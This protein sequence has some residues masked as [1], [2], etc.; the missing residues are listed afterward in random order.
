MLQIIPQSQFKSVPWKNGGGTTREAIRVP[1]QGAA[2]VWRVSVA[3]IDA[4]GPF[5]DF[6]AYNRTMVLLKGSGLELEFGNGQRSVLNRMAEMA[7]FDGALA[8]HCRLLDGPC[9][10]LNLMVAKTKPMIAR[11]ESLQL[12][13]EV[14]ASQGESTLIFG[15]DTGLKL[16]IGGDEPRYLEPWDLAI[17]TNGA[18]RVTREAGAGAAPVAVFIA[19]IHH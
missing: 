4:S 8:T 6:A 16:E 7:Q 2:F 18:V 14:R 3:Q 19:T 13:V 17:V 15:I 9:V 10:D 5:S 1:V 11:V 12:S